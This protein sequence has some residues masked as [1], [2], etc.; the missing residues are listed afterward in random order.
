M[1]HFADL[2]FYTY[3]GDRW[4]TAKNVGWLKQ[5]HA[6]PTAA[7]SEE[8]LDLLWQFCSAPVMK[9]RGIHACDL[10]E[11]RQAT[12]VERNGVK[13]LL[14]HAE[15]RV[16]SAESSADSLRRALE[17]TESGGLISLQRSPVPF[18]IYAAPTLIYHYVEAHHYS[19]PEE[20]LRAMRNGVQPTTPAYFELLRKFEISH[21]G[22][23]PL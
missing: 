1:A 4:P 16:F 12:Y 21:D 19:P 6:F 9:M 3:S 17:Q 2:T 22:F 5:G 14:G 11:T 15:I 8:T 18:S 10:C 13:L 20:F 23:R 7:P